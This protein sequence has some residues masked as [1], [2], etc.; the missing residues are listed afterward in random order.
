MILEMRI[1]KYEVRE[2]LFKKALGYEYTEPDKEAKDFILERKITIPRNIL[3][4]KEWDLKENIEFKK[5]CQELNLYIE[6][7]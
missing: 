7:K 3:N 2:Q 6:H 1:Y 4:Y 5:A